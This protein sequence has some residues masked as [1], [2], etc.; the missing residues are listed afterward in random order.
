MSLASRR[1]TELLG[2]MMIGDSVAA[3]ADPR[4]HVGLWSEGPKAWRGAMRP[5]ARHPGMT[6]MLGAA[7]LVAGLWFIGRLKPGR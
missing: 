4:R 3:I 2:L 5:F 6:R 7:G 1:A